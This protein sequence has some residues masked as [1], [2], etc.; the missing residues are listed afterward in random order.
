M[1]PNPNPSPRRRRSPP[2]RVPKRPTSQRR[3]TIPKKTQRPMTRRN[4]GVTGVACYYCFRYELRSL[5]F[6]L[7][8]S[9]S[10]FISDGWSIANGPF[11]FFLTPPF[12]LSPP[13]VSRWLPVLL[14]YIQ[15]SLSSHRN[16]LDQG[17]R[18]CA[19]GWM[20]PET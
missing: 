18:I 2:P 11:A 5:F 1:S 6:F 10:L 12:S 17:L 14:T 20:T 15:N 4:K 8:N 9:P 3:P 19:G 7:G 13:F 16:C